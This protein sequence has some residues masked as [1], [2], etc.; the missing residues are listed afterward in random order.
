[1]DFS[2][3]HGFEDYPPP[4][5]KRTSGKLHSQFSLNDAPKIYP[6]SSICRKRYSSKEIQI[7]CILYALGPAK[8][9]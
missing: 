8:G 7:N 1:M 3:F 6:Q 2:L 4:P 5:Q 9:I